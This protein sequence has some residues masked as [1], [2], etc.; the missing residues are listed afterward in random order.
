[1]VIKVICNLLNHEK[2]KV[3]SPQDLEHIKIVLQAYNYGSGLH[4]IH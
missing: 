1:M 4:Y 3:S 2:I